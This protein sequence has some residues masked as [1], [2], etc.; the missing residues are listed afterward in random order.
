MAAC[1]P[2]SATPI[3][4]V[5]CSPFSTRLCMLCRLFSGLQD[6]STSLTVQPLSNK[7]GLNIQVGRH[8]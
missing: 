4:M 7:Q 3:F 1:M 6:C 8:C 2:R 5:D